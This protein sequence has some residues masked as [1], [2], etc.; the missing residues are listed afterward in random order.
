MLFHEDSFSSTFRIS[1]RLFAPVSLSH[2]FPFLKNMKVG[3]LRTLNCVAK[4]WLLATSTFAKI[5]CSPYSFD[6]LRMIGVMAWQGPH[7]FAQKSTTTGLPFLRRSGKF[8]IV[9]SWILPLMLKASILD[10]YSLEW[11]CWIIFSM[12]ISGS[13]V[14][15]WQRFLGFDLN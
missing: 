11:Y 10:S 15:T 9:A 12:S 7:Q 3:M 2:S 6:S 5:T 14:Q 4:S 8:P 1:L 13:S